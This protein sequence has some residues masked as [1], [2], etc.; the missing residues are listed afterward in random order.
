MQIEQSFRDMK[1]QHFGEG[2][3]RS[4]SRGTERFRVLVRIASLAAFLLWLIGRAVERVGLD[5]RLHPGNGTRRVDSRV[6]VARVLPVLD[7]TRY[8]LDKLL[9]TIR[10]PDQWVPSDHDALL[11]DGAGGG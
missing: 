2:L 3:E 9:A 4:R 6:F 7:S 1:H 5:R 10:L 11:G 8:V